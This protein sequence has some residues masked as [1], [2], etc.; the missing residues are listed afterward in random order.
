MAAE[1]AVTAG[2][3]VGNPRVAVFA[4]AIVICLEDVQSH[5]V[6]SNA[7]PIARTMINAAFT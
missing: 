4:S 3:F 1:D 7:A 5:A 6:N 2:N